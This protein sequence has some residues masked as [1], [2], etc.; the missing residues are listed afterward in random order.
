MRWMVRLGVIIFAVLC[1]IKAAPAEP[2]GS[3][4]TTSSILRYV[5]LGDSIAYGYGLS[6]R[7]TQS[8][9]S[10]IRQHLEDSY[11]YVVETNLGTNGQESTDLLDILTNKDNDMY[12]KYRASLSY[13]DIVT[14]SI[15]SN[16]LLHL[17]Q[18]DSD[19]DEMIK[20][21]S[22]MFDEACETF[23]ENFPKIISAIRRINPDAQIYVDNIY[24]PAIHVSAFEDVYDIAEYYITKMNECFYDSDDYGLVDVKEAFDSEDKSLINL[25]IQ[26]R[27]IDPH[28]NA[29]G[30][31]KIAEAVIRKMGSL[32]L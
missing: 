31:L 10:L 28:P 25:M 21:G 11:D 23:G 3:G 7:Q 17:I 12:K 15:G 30:H 2:V 5:A 18:L 27:G 9:V 29:A 22:Q 14:L 1:G 20:N 8:Y 13:A 16:D 32:R 24:N 4:D 6:D 26:G 19:M